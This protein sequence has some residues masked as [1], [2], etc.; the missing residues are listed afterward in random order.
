MGMK[1][2]YIR[3][4]YELLLG[5]ESP[6]HVQDVILN[7]NGKR[8]EIRLTA[9]EGMA[10]RCGR[11]GR[12]APGYDAG[13]ERQWR[14]LDTMGFET[15]LCARVPRVNCPEHGVS[16]AEV[17]WADRNQR[18]TL[19]F[20]AFAIKVLQACGT[21]QQAADLL[22][23]DWRSAQAI[24]NRAVTRGLA[25]RPA[26]PV[27]YV[28]LD[29]KSFRSRQSYVSVMVDISQGRVLE[30]Q[31]GSDTAAARQ[32]WAQYPSEQR[33]KVEAVAMDLSSAF[34]AASA[35]A[36]PDAQ[37]VYDRYHLME[38]MVR[39]VD[40]VR[41][42]ENRHLLRE[43]DKL[44]NGTR[45]LW[46]F[47]PHH[48]GEE[49]R[50]R[51]QRLCGRAEKTGRAWALKELLQELWKQP[52]EI[53][54]RALFRRWY[55]WAIRTRLAP[56]KRVART[57]KLYLHGIL[58][59]FRHRITNAVTEGLNS[60]IQALKSMARGIRLFQHYRTRILFYCG[61]LDLYPITRA[62]SLC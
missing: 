19:M 14:H 26:T 32:L 49:D 57:F 31:E 59:W 13:N 44:L 62:H 25:R 54:G 30:V 41:R 18:F 55:A 46:L 3:R 43:G 58:A 42:Q 28:G 34:M 6:W 17:T 16:T 24:M 2:Q 21:V 50:T 10:L 27:R 48:L 11:C 38:L 47:N 29:E 56:V 22:G 8:I 53:Q 51:L 7:V 40:L 52:D 39:A 20:E 23:L 60:K 12:P 15:Y 1:T 4:H 33:Q 45:S 5:V 9:K 35:E 36:V 37:Q 61:K